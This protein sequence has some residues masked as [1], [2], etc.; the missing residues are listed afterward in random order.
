MRRSIARRRLTCVLV[1]VGLSLTVPALPAAAHGPAPDRPP[2]LNLE[3]LTGAQ[4]EKMLAEGK[5]T[6]VQLT[7]AYLDRIQA[8]NKQGPGLNAVTQLNPDALKE[9]AL[10]DRERAEGHHL[11]PAQGLPILMKDLIDVKGMYTSAGNYSLRDS[12][13]ATDAGITKKLR[14]HGVVILG[15]V[16]LSEFANSFGS[17][18]S[19]FSNLTGQVLNGIDADQNPSGSSSGTGAAMASAMAT[20]GIGTETSGSIISPSSTQGLVGLRPTVGLVPGYGIAP[21]DA[22]QDTA[23]P[24]ARSVTDAA[25]TLQSIAGPDPDADKEYRD[26]FG[27]DYLAAGVIPTPPATVPDYMSALNLNFVRGKE[28]GYNGTLTDGSPLK[29]A[30]DALTAAGAI[31]V[32]RPSTSVGT[33]PSLPNGYEQH[34][35]IDEYY[36]RLGPQAPIQSLAQEVVDNQAN[37][38]Q[39]L[40]FGNSQHLSESQADITPGGANE[41]Q[42]RT[43]LPVRKTAYHKAIDDMMDYP[44]S[45]PTQAAD[46]VIAILGSVPSGPQAGYPQM[47]IPM[48]YNATTRR[49]LNVSVNGNAY[50]ERNLIGVGYVIEQAT[51]LRQPA[52]MVDPSL[53]RCAHTT[54]AEPFAARGACNPDY[55]AVMKLLGGTAPKALPFSLETESATSLEARLNAGTLTSEQLVRQYLYRIALT[56]AEGPAIQAVRDLN[57]HAIDDARTLDKQRKDK[58]KPHGP[59]YGLPVL[60]DDSIDARGM[61]TTGGSIALQNSTPRDDSAIVARLRA[62]GAIVL[63]KT[64]VTELNGVFDTNLPEG[65]SS[66]GGQVLVASDTDKTPAGSSGGSA[67]ATAAGLAAITVGMETSTDT[68]QLIAPAGAAGVVGLK[69]TVGLVSRAGV[70]PVAKSQDSPGPIGRTVGDVATELAAIAGPD[71]KDPATLHAPPVP[72]YTAG[73]RADALQGKRIAVVTSS[74]APYAA[75]VAA[76]KAQGA[77]VVPVSVPAPSPNPPSIVSSEYQRDLNAYLSGIPGPGAKSLQQIIAYNNAHP[78]EGLKYQQGELVAAQSVNLSDPATAAQ[79]AANLTAGQASTRAAIDSIVDGGTPDDPSDDVDAIMVPNGDATIGIADRAG[80]PA[81]TIPAGYGAT[82]S[83]SGHDPVGVTLVGTAFSEARLLADGY[84]LEQ[85]TQVRLAPSDTNPSMWRCVP[86]STFFTGELCNPGDRQLRPEVALPALATSVAAMGLDKSVARELTQGVNG[87]VRALGSPPA[88]CRALDDL[89]RQIGRD[90]G[91]RGKLTGNQAAA[92]RTAET[93]VAVELRC[94]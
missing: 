18:P 38:Q 26:V 36:A 6:S 23:G 73:L 43:N 69:P 75:M 53:Y 49:T 60:L 79:Y 11:G 2:V 1:S 81:L 27:P 93:P 86:G 16:G 66:L 92:L 45:D 46:P 47:T 87:V 19:G 48:G 22:S 37:A 30:Y 32:P 78:V 84:A 33:I 56:N 89:D 17:Q 50:D 77:T 83:S 24:M 63:G 39:S 13:P 55:Q 28:I 34:K 74:A 94:G 7:R 71:P 65:Y 70:L 42:F 4:A 5:L 3:T 9:A 10:A 67:A 91:G 41:T 54:P 59:L 25:M 68:A 35:T 20:L 40:K 64:N 88:A 8:L 72:D 85:A 76:L 80:Y 31:M 62:A 52:S 12:Y 21:I 14:A 51:K 58:K 15:K 82:D 44:N 90:T 29:L 61:P 57:S